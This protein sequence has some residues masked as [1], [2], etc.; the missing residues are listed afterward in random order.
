[1]KIRGYLRGLLEEG[2]F[3]FGCTYLWSNQLHIVSDELKKT[4]LIKKY[5]YAIIVQY[6]KTSIKVKLNKI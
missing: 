2:W 4:P 3:R 1:M 6:N 5:V